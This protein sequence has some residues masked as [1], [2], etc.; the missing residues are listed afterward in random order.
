MTT[1]YIDIAWRD[2]PSRITTYMVHVKSIE[3]AIRH[4]RKNYKGDTILGV[5]Q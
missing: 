4:A 5:R 1:F 3:E 2:D